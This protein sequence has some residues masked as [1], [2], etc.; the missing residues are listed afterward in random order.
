MS[1][2][3][4]VVLV[5]VGSLTSGCASTGSNTGST[6]SAVVLSP[7]SHLDMWLEHPVGELVIIGERAYVH[8]AIKVDDWSESSRNRR[9]CR[10]E[11]AVLLGQYTPCASG[12]EGCISIGYASVDSWRP[13]VESPVGE[14]LHCWASTYT[15]LVPK[16]LLSR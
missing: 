7:T 3:V 5:V 10:S 16:A 4:L 2:I 13:K 6:G 11:A 15:N 14:Y 8:A 1:K 12:E 9:A